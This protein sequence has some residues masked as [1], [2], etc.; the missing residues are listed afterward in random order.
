MIDAHISEEDTPFFHLS[1]FLV[2]QN[3]GKHRLTDSK[4]Q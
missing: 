1:V 2:P 4:A 3:K